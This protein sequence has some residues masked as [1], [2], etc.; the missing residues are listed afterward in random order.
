MSLQQT[1]PYHKAAFDSCFVFLRCRC[2]TVLGH[3]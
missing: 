3:G 1:S 2:V